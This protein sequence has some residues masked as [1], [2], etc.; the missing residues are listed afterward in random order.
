MPSHNLDVPNFP[1]TPS[2][3]TSSVNLDASCP[4]N[5]DHDGRSVLSIE[6]IDHNLTID[7]R[8]MDDRWLHV[9]LKRSS[10][11]QGV[12]LGSCQKFDLKQNLMS[13]VPLVD[14]LRNY[15]LKKDFMADIIAGVTVAIMQIPQGIAYAL[16]VG[17][18]PNYG[19]YTSFFP[20]LIYAFFG[21]AQ[22]ISL[23]TMAVVDI[24][25]RDIVSKHRIY[26][27]HHT[28]LTDMSTTVPS[29]VVSSSP[30]VTAAVTGISEDPIEILTSLC[31]LVGLFQ[32]AF[33]ILRLG[34]V[35]LIL[36]D[37]L[38]SGFSCGA[39]INVIMSQ[40]PPALGLR[41]PESGGP[42]SLVYVSYDAHPVVKQFLTFYD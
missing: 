27:R 3:E 22:H 30:V 38:I 39:S 33:G 14:R 20:V 8:T 31:L 13:L 42:L 35:S 2:P 34:A 24:M 41:I 29:T 18:T 36:S 40:V 11:L 25:L 15:D 7:S 28:N 17:I 5:G 19:L 26:P 37:Q 6:T 16:L 12:K 10:P 1:S 32:I 23:G 4:R 9:D 21:T